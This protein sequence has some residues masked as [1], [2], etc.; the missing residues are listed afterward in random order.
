MT[1]AA[2]WQAFRERLP[3]LFD[4][5]SE[6]ASTPPTVLDSV[7]AIMAMVELAAILS[8]LGLL[9]VGRERLWFAQA[10]GSS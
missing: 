3:F 8:S 7:I 2:M 1:A 5:W 9:V 10:V 6:R 4:P